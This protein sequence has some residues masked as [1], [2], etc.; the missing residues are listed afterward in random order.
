M[1]LPFRE[2]FQAWWNSR[3]VAQ[4]VWEFLP[5]RQYWRRGGNAQTAQTEWE[6]HRG[7]R[8]NPKILRRDKCR[9]SRARWILGFWRN[10]RE[11][12]QSVRGFPPRRQYCR[13]DGSSQ[14]GQNDS[15]ASLGFRPSPKIIRWCEFGI[16][17]PVGS[18][19]FRGNPREVAPSGWEFLP[20][21]QYCRRGGMPRLLGSLPVD[22][23]KSLKSFACGNFEFVLPCGLSGFSEIHEQ[24]PSQS[25]NFF[26]A[27]NIVGVAEIP[28]LTRPDWATARGF[29]QNPKIPRAG[30]F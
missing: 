2:T 30:K 22:F 17:P 12:A 13:L 27:D 10:P 28:R 16:S 9:I 3:A 25:V 18:F 7:F 23:D 20:H 21:R 6:T 11:V 14:T 24:S 29:H 15:A 26:N 1:N 19:G 8:R 5:R 4:S